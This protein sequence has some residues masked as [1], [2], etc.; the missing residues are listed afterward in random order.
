MSAVRAGDVVGDKYLRRPE[1]TWSALSLNF[2]SL[3]NVDAKIGQLIEHDVKYEGYVSRQQVQV[4][5]QER[6]AKK[7]IPDWFDYNEIVSL[8]FEAKQKLGKFDRKH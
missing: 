2:P 3:A 5:R 4:D 6:M 1:V 8:R 7:K